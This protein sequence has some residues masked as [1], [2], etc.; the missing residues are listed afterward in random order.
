MNRTCSWFLLLI[1]RTVDERGDECE[2][3]HD[4]LSN[5]GIVE[6]VILRC[7]KVPKRARGRPRR[8]EEVAGSASRNLNDDTVAPHP[9]SKPYWKNWAIEE[10]RVAD[11]ADAKAIFE[12]DIK[13]LDITPRHH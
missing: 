12:K 3:E 4:V 11:P 9:D 7:N 13:S 1:W 2:R 10:E 6:V 8:G 5:I